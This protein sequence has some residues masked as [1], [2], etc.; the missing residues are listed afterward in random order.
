[1][2][3]LTF[4]CVW[5]CGVWVV[6]AISLCVDHISILEVAFGGDLL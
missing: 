6:M 4:A 3:L 2:V 1:M 5:C